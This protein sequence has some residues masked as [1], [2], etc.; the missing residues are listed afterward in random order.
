MKKQM[1]FIVII[2]FVIVLFLII[3]FINSPISK[4]N[5]IYGNDYCNIN[6][7]IEGGGDAFTEWTCKLC[8]KS[9]T[10][11]DTNVPEIC[12]MCSVL[13]GRCN[14]CGKLEK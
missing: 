9:A 2:I 8:G 13:T 14:K 6:H 4:A 1:K 3:A 7:Y 5:K 11:S 10:N 12:N